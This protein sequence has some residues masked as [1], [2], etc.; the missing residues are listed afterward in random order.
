MQILTFEIA[1]GVK[2]LFAAAMVA[3]L[4]PMGEQD[5]PGAKLTSPRHHQTEIVDIRAWDG[6]PRAEVILSL[7]STELNISQI[8]RN[9][10]KELPEFKDREA[11]ERGHEDF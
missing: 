2:S 8:D 1:T 3:Q 7:A 6:N 11:V 10:L 5:D 9:F 4:Q